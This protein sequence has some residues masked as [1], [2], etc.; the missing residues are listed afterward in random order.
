MKIKKE[1]QP[2]ASLFYRASREIFHLTYFGR[3]SYVIF[4]GG[5]T[6]LS[7]SKFSLL[8]PEDSTEPNGTLGIP[9][10]VIGV[11]LEFVLLLIPFVLYRAIA[12]RIKSNP[13]ASALQHYE[14][15]ETGL[16]NYG[17]GFRVDLSWNKLTH[18]K[19]S[20][21]FILLFTSWNAAYFIPK[22][23]FSDAEVAQIR[24]WKNADM[25]RFIRANESGR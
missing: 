1:F 6:M 25:L 9:N 22:H 24:R 17:D 12:K 20:R 18:V 4:L 21:S 11:I 7:V 23:L 16:R 5:S 10:W 19:L 14:I 3:L 15:S 13:F 2:N 8:G